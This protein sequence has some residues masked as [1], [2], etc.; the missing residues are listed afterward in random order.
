MNTDTNQPEPLDVE[1][2]KKL[3][4]LMQINESAGF[5]PNSDTYEFERLCVKHGAALLSAYEQRQ[6]L[7]EEVES[8]RLM[9]AGTAKEASRQSDALCA[10]RAENS[11]LQ[12]E[13]EKSVEESN[14]RDQKWMEG[15]D[16]IV[17]RKLRY[18]LATIND[19][20]GFDLV[21]DLQDFIRDLRA[22]R[23][24][25]QARAQR[26]ERHN[27]HAESEWRRHQN[28]ADEAESQL[29]SLHQQLTAALARAEGADKLLKECAEKLDNYANRQGS[30]RLAKK[31]LSEGLVDNSVNKGQHYPAIQSLIDMVN[32][33]LKS[34]ITQSPQ[35]GKT[36]GGAA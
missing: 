9:L 11:R 18:T 31:S 13:V 2:L 23:D 15:I 14:R 30:R 27:K 29:A 21:P 16:S 35:D 4:L 7:Q 22:S 8:Y 28:R 24:A 32:N 6:A 33:F 36:E 10:L 20:P 19:S 26:A 25:V 12:G 3:F 1:A 5:L 17:G 34:R